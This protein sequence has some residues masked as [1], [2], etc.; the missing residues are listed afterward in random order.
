MP[1]I[2]HIPFAYSDG[3]GFGHHYITQDDSLPTAGQFDI[4]VFHRGDKSRRGG[5]LLRDTPHVRIRTFD[6]TDW[7]IAS[8]TLISKE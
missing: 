3:T 8:I 1:R 6:G 5:E 2:R 7:N 4:T